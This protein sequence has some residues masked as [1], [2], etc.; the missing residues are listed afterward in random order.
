M[1]LPQHPPNNTPSTHA[2]ILSLARNNVKR[3]EKLE[4]V[5]G[6]LEE[7][8]LSYNDV[9]RLDGVLCLQNWRVLYMSNNKIG[10]VDEIAKLADLPNLVD[11]V[12]YGNPFMVELDK[13]SYRREVVKRIPQ[14]SKIDGEMITPA[15]REEAA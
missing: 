6:T 4:E 11:V 8:W 13:A 7:L 12:F 3:V 9:S 15:E 5:A 1:F 10:D 14:L 2:Q